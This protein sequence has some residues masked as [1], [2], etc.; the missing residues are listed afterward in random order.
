M[1]KVT[2]GKPSSACNSIWFQSVCP[3][4]CTTVPPTWPG[5]SQLLAFTDPWALKLSLQGAPLDRFLY[6]HLIL[7]Q[8][9][10]GQKFHHEQW[11]VSKFFI[12]YKFTILSQHFSLLEL[13]CSFAF[14]FVKA[15]QHCQLTFPGSSCEDRFSCRTLTGKWRNQY[16]SKRGAK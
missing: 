9:L 15:S 12:L 2:Q 8:T 6:P 16:E 4:H 11:F 13:V 1:A 10:Q 14:Y 7:A 3:F 5:S